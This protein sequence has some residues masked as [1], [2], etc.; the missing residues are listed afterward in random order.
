MPFSLRGSACE[1]AANR[2]VAGP[3]AR[4]NVCRLLSRK[5]CVLPRVLS[6]CLVV[7]LFFPP[8]SAFNKRKGDIGGTFGRAASPA[9][10]S[11]PSTP[12]TNENSTDEWDDAEDRGEGNMDNRG[13]PITAGDRAK[14]KRRRDNGQGGKGFGNDRASSAPPRRLPGSREG[15]SRG[16]HGNGG[17]HAAEGARGGLGGRRRILSDDG[18][19]TSTEEETSSDE[20]QHFL[21]RIMGWCTPSRDALPSQSPSGHVQRLSKLVGECLGGLVGW[22]GRFQCWGKTRPP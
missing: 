18:D 9:V 5:T 17:R 1:P 15:I 4:C 7:K 10:Y 11:R 13:R 8:S 2:K 3:P 12:S 19:S 14:E 21:R 22:P 6:R 20:V 16:G